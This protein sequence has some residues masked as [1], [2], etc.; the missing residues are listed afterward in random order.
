LRCNCFNGLRGRT[1]PVATEIKLANH[2]LTVLALGGDGDGY[3][4]GRNHFL[5]AMRR[6][7]NITYLVHDNQV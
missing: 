3:A 7:V 5:H 6:N 4:E 2:K 1:L